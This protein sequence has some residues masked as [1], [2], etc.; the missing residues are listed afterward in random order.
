MERLPRV[1]LRCHGV[2]ARHDSVQAQRH[3]EEGTGGS[4]TGYVRRTSCHVAADFQRLRL[5]HTDESS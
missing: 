1:P 4:Y 3:A 2:V 5:N